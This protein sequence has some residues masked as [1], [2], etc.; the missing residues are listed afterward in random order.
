MYRTVSV[1][2][3]L[4]LLA[5]VA[6]A[7]VPSSIVVQGKLT[8][9]AGNPLPAGSKTFQFRIFNDTLAGAQ[10]WPSG[11]L[12]EQQ[13]IISDAG[14]LWVARVGALSPLVENDFDNPLRWLQI[15]VDGTTLP[16]IRIVSEPYA[17]RVATVDGASGGIITGKVSIG[18]NNT[19]SGLSAFVVGESNVTSGDFSTI[20][21][22][23]NNRARGEFSFVGGGGGGQPDSNSASGAWSSVVGGSQN[24]ASGLTSF[25]GGGSGNIAKSGSAAIAGGTN[26]RADTNHNFIGGGRDNHTDQFDAM[27]GGGWMNEALG[28]SSAILGGRGNVVRGT[29]AVIVGGNYNRASGSFSFVGGGGNQPTDSNSALGPGSVV[30]GGSENYAQGNLSFVGGG[31][32]NEAGAQYATLPGGYN[33]EANGEYSTVGGGFSNDVFGMSAVI[34][35]GDHNTSTGPYS[36]ISGGDQNESSGPYSVIGGGRFNLATGPYSVVA[37]GGGTSLN[38]RNSANGSFST[39]GGG[40]YNIADSSYSTVSGGTANWCYGSGGT[41]SG[42]HSNAITETSRDAAIGGGGSNLATG[43]YATVPGGRLN[44]ATGNYSFASGYRAHASHVGTFVWADS[45]ATIFGSSA[46]HQF[47]IRASGG[48]GIGTN[49]PDA[50][51]HV[52]DGSAGAVTGNGNASLVCERNGEN[53]LHILSPEANQRGILFG[54][55]TSSLMGS[56]RFNPPGTENGFNFRCGTNNTRLVLDSLGNLTADGCVVGSNIACPSDARFKKDISTIPNALALVEQLRGVN[57]RWQGEQFPDRE[58]PEGQQVG[59]IAQEVREIVPQ[60]VIE[61]SDGYL[62]VDYARLVPLLIE[63]MKEQQ[64]QIDEL[65]TRL[66]RQTP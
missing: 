12:P 39:V 32:R 9:N 2:I 49:A 45:G 20:A 19:N 17:F 4:C 7:A 31:T 48:V 58:F 18:Q 40:E 1:L 59:L 62:A 55:P 33:N 63:G 51:L 42:G 66:D 46:A 23:S 11:G 36:V 21:G 15:T 47:L 57:Y 60:A 35:G 24:V 30:V 65:K 22:G 27:V 34:S 52:M 64:K 50:A 54:S 38:A 3:A 56:I 5:A 6:L 53:W 44:E 29:G 41:I 61:Q 26:N 37:G 28:N 16:R 13:V 25:V 14:G 8:D 43:S 10:V